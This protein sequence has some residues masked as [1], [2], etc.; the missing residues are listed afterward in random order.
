MLRC[1]AYDGVWERLRQPWT[2]TSTGQTAN[3]PRIPRSKKYTKTILIYPW[4][5]FS[6]SLPEVIIKGL[7]GFGDSSWL[8]GSCIAHHRRRQQVSGFTRSAAFAILKRS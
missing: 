8:F 2:A 4:R 5:I 7:A 6:G 3:Y 1:E